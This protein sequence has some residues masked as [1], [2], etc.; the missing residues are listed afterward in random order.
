MTYAS[1]LFFTGTFDRPAFEAALADAI[2]AHPLMSALIQPA[3]QGKLC[4]V[5]ARGVTPKLSWGGLHDPIEFEDGEPIDLTKEVG[6]RVWVRQ[7]APES[8]GP[9]QAH[10]V[11]Q[12]HHACSDG[13]GAHRFMGDLLAAYGM[14]TA[15]GERCP[16]MASYDPQ[17]LKS[18]RTK[19]GERVFGKRTS[20]IRMGIGEG[21][22][23]FGPKITPLS[24]NGTQPQAATTPVAFPDVVSHTFD[25]AEHKQLR[26]VAGRMGGMLNDLLMAE[27]FLAMRDWN[28]EHGGNSRQRLRIMMPSDMRNTTDYA[29]PAANM[30]SYN[31]VTRKI[32]HRDESASL[33]RSMRDET[34]RI[35]NEQRGTRF[36]DSIMLADT[37]PGL[38]SLLLSR[39]R[40]LSTV[41]LSNMGD[42]TRR[43]LATFPRED[44]KLVCG[45]V[46]LEKML[47]VSP[48]RPMTRAAVSVV[49][50]YRQLIINIRCDPH[51]MSVTDAQDF[52]D[53]YIRRLSTHT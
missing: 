36:I 35:R 3:K 10:L 14:R 34:A 43:F 23:V 47:G 50:F 37:V 29:M 17:L 20:L 45:N 25:K 27:M 30:T 1:N 4:W 52:L 5:D 40:C 8:G 22:Q 18:R 46:V 41:T 2:D 51:T 48:L 7:G 28:L 42:P 33:V 49:T 16:A 9:G 44:G 38:L 32:S 53:H 12:F 26:N 19:L 39:K 24:L 15:T 31:F 21:V 6:L 13:T 11:L